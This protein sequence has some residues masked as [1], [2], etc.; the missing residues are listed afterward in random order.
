MIAHS[1]SVRAL[2]AAPR[3]IA[4][5]VI[6]ATVHLPQVVAPLLRC[7]A[8]KP[9]TKVGNLTVQVGQVYFLVQSGKF[10]GYFY[11][12]T[13]NQERNCWQCSCGAG[14]KHHEH[15]AKVNTYIR[16]NVRKEVA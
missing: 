10:A 8:L 14:C 2:K 3:T 11:I 4:Q 9:F 16:V 15:I 7:E 13:W 12:V 6:D 1:K 5:H